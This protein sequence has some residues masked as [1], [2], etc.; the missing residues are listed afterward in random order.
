MKRLPRRVFT[1]EFNKE[2]VLL[3]KQ[4]DLTV[5]HVSRNL[6]IVPKSPK[7]WVEFVCC[8]HT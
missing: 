6:D 2:A 5:A 3:F 4:Q 8:W 7:I 1:E